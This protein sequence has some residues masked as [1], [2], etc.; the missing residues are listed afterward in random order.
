MQ[1]MPASL[2]NH[3]PM[4]PIGRAALR[5]PWVVGRRPVH[6]PRYPDDDRSSRRVISDEC[7]CYEDGTRLTLSTA[8]ESTRPFSSKQNGSKSSSV[9]YQVDARPTAGATW[10]DI[11][12]HNSPSSCRE[13]KARDHWTFP[14]S[15]T[16]P[17]SSDYIRWPGTQYRSL[18]GIHKRFT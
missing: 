3:R 18:L 15:R 17:P 6:P 8:L 2:S 9:S 14:S 12:R 7:S 1:A 13:T 10:S 16:M 11:P 4:R 5:P